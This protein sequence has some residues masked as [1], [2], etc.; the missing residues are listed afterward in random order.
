MRRIIRAASAFSLLAGAVNG[1][2]VDFTNDDSIKQAASTVAYG[3]LKYYTGNN[4]G[5][6]PGNL[7]DP[8]FWWEAGAMF[9]TMVDYWFLTGDESYV[10]VTKQALVHQ[11]GDDKD[12]MPTNQTRTMGNDDQG[13]WAMAAMSAAENNFPNPPADQPQWLALAQAVFNEYVDR[14]DPE[15]CNGGLRW[16][17]FTFNNGYNYKNSIS[18][19]CFFNIAARLARYTGNQTYADWA[20]KVWDW[21]EEIGFIDEQYN[22][23]DGA[24]VEAE[25]TEF[26]RPQWTYNAGIFLHGAAVMYNVYNTSSDASTEIG[27]GNATAGEVWAQRTQGMM[28]RTVDL[29]YNGTGVPTEHSCEPFNQCNIDQ[30]SFKGYLMRWMTG[31]AQMAP[32]TFDTLMPLVQSAA[33]AAALQCSGSPPADQFRG[34]PGTACGFKWTQGA[35]FDGLVGV[36][37]QMSALSAIQYTLVK[38]AEVGG[39]DKVPVTANSGGTSIGNVNAGASTE[40]KIPTPKPISTAERVAAGFATTAVLF[41]V[42]GGSFF[43]MKE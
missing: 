19:G 30:Q 31:T 23:F 28:Q 21:M 4:T 5:D 25:C 7:P 8:Y 22:V 9:G 39:Q 41:S 20:E 34:D 35:D 1:L 27:G 16:Q 14:W 36:G 24:G 18:N 15:T 11:A 3:L 42:L 37:E 10:E 32:F 29:F 12:Y 2:Q 6:T 40:S 13:F 38:K 17:V 33:A 43:V 26:S